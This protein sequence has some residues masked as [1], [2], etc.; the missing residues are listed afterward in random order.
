MQE[1][2]VKVHADVISLA[3]NPTASYFVTVCV[4]DMPLQLM[5]DSGAAVSLLRK[6]QWVRLVG[7]TAKMEQ[8]NGGK[9]VGVNGSPVE[10]EGVVTMEIV[11]GGHNFCADFIVVGALKVQSLIALDFL[12]KYDCVIDIPRM[13]LWLQGAAVPLES[14]AMWRTD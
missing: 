8:W 5:V 13:R 7:P 12:K 4:N 1:G 9:L 3:D 11:I 2:I 14:L 6:D 10:V